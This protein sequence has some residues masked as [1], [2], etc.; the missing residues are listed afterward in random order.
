MP[1]GDYVPALSHMS[2]MN[3]PTSVTCVRMAAV[4]IHPTPTAVTAMRDTGLESLE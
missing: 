1:I 3:V 2:V 4:L